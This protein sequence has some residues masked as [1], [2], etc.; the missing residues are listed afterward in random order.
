[1]RRFFKQLA[2]LAI[3]PLLAR[4]TEN[5]PPPEFRNGYQFPQ[6]VNPGPRPELFLLLDV[7]MLALALGLA[8]YFALKM[9]S[10]R[11]LQVLTI[12]SVLYFGFYRHGCV[13]AVGALQNVAMA[14]GQSDYALTFTIAAFFLLPLLAALFFGR[15]FCAGVCPLGALQDLLLQRPVRLPAW[16][17]HPLSLLP[18][19][20]LGAAVLFA[21]TGSAFV[22][23]MYD[24]FVSL[25]RLGGSLTMLLGGGVILLLAVFVGRPYC[26]FLCPYSV[27]LRALAPLAKW[28]M[29]ITRQGCVHC[30]LCAE[31]CPFGAIR[32]PTP[33]SP[34]RE[35]FAGRWQLAAL[36]IA[37]PLLVGVGGWLG[38]HGAGTLYRVH[39]SVQQA[40][41]ARQQDVGPFP[42]DPASPNVALY[43]RALA[44][45]TQF[46]LGGMLF[47]AWIGLLIGGKLLAL[48]LRRQR[49]EYEIDQGAC[50]A[51]GRCYQV[52][53]VE[54]AGVAVPPVIT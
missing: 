39:P 44:I 31:A 1:M 33:P 4:A 42:L 23:C 54:R 19:V 53:P 16:L 11:H 25:F 32:P 10:R 30:H 34:P 49:T 41:A 17:E 47:G 18:A 52:C 5:F 26:R 36:L 51:C 21:A 7:V 13:C 38:R 35:R 20:Y 29:L 43:R 6:S 40:Q 8:A 22:I 46:V 2:I 3:F 9:R 24:P 14:F 27:F 15:V 12:F 50:M 37:L 48:S 45:H 28:R